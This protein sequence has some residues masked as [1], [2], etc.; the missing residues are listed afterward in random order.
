VGLQFRLAPEQARAR[1]G[2]GESCKIGRAGEA[3]TVSRQIVMLPL[4]YLQSRLLGP[5][6]LPLSNQLLRTSR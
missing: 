2:I 3:W 6:M 5:P 1:S 4:P